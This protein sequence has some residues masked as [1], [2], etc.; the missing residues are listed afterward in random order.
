MDAQRFPFVQTPSLRWPSRSD[1]PEGTGIAAKAVTDAPVLDR[2]LV[3]A[4]VLSE[5]AVTVAP[6]V[7]SEDAVA[8]A[9]PLLPVLEDWLCQPHALNDPESSALAAIIP[10]LWLMTRA[11]DTTSTTT[12]NLGP[13]LPCRPR[14]RCIPLMSPPPRFR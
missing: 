13:G 11:K 5:D 14:F 7:L 2:S 4:L 9:P 8:V 3:G 6:L 12:S 1:E 10:R